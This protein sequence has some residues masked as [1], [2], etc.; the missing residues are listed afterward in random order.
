[1]CP[2]PPPMCRG[3]YVNVRSPRRTLKKLARSGAGK[4][5]SNNAATRHNSIDSLKMTQF[6][7]SPSRLTR[8]A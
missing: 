7:G 5:K 2:G 4:R 6:R 1:M 8:L 3:W